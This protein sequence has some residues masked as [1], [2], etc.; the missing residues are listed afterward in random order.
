MHRYLFNSRSAALSTFALSTYSSCH[1]V[2]SDSGINNDH[3][4]HQPS[5]GASTNT[6]VRPKIFKKKEKESITIES[7][8]LLP[9]SANRKLSQEI[10]DFINVPLSEVSLSRF[11]DGEVSL[12]IKVN[13]RGKHVFIIQ[14]CSA[15]VN[16]SIMELLLSISC[17][18]RAGASR[19]TAVIPYFGYKHHRR[20][21]NI[22]TKHSSR[23]LS[24]TSMDFAKM[25]QEM[26]ADRVISVDLQRPGQGHEACFFDNTVPLETVVTTDLFIEYFTKNAYLSEPILVIAP[27]AE[28]VKRAR[29]FQKKL[30]KHYS[31]PVSFGAF[32]A[33]DTG[34]GPTDT[35]K[36][37]MLGNARVR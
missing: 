13:V 7:L 3:V 24:S 34:S 8:V 28:G 5:F 20:S 30:Q 31:L 14:P 29:K 16:D 4:V 21:A 37:E 19:I 23:Y 12:Q 2:F 22:S 26:G 32:F 10:A 17:A 11:A 33:S 15:P 36:L 27:N 35:S 25:I 6:R 1:G 9:G 18:R